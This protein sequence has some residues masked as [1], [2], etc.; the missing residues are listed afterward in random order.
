MV[1]AQI[2][3]GTPV[4]DVPVVFVKDKPENLQLSVNEK[5]AKA[6]GVTLPADLISQAVNKF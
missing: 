1:A 6:Q 2:L 5:A 4:A 3:S